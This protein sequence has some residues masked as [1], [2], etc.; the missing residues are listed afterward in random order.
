MSLP[1]GLALLMV[2]V[3]AQGLGRSV[4]HSR[5]A[6]LRPVR[7][8]VVRVSLARGSTARLVL[9]PARGSTARVTGAKC[10]PSRGPSAG[11]ERAGQTCR[12]SVP[13]ERAG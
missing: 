4:R 6:P 2:A 13:A 10:T 5:G 9:F 12:L 11:A 8:S 3:L 7:V 1:L